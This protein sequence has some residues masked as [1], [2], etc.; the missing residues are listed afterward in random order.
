M[1][2]CLISGGC[3]FAYGFNLRNRDERYAKILADHMTADLIDTSAAG[4]TNEF[5]A[6]A[7]ISGIVKALEINQYQPEELLVLVGWTT[8]ERFEYFNRKVGRIM[9]GYVNAALHVHGDMTQQD[10]DRSELISKELWDPSYG[11]YKLVH[12]FNYLNSF[13]KAHNV[14]IVHIANIP[15]IKAR[16][17]SVK[18]RNAAINNNDII[19]GSL[20]SEVETALTALSGERT[21]QELT[22]RDPFKYTLNPKFDTHPNS[23]GHAMWAEKLIQKYDVFTNT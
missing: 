10:K 8:T 17:P 16:F 4:M 6:A 21:F 23:A 9:S 18:L 15:H 14:K 2:K 12:A 7:T 19:R 22:M 5:I 3:S 1:I 11:Y 13:C 20:T